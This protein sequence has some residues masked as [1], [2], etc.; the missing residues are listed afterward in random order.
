MGLRTLLVLL[1][2]VAYWCRLLM[3]LLL[4]G[5]LA[6]TLGGW[7]P[8]YTRSL[9]LILHVSLRVASLAQSSQECK[10]VVAR[11]SYGLTAELSSI[12]STALC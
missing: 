2:G 3:S 11:P 9:G 12:T 6:E 5:R 1:T 10:A 4:V 7:A 8:L